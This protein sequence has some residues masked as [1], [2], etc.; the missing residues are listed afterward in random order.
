MRGE[1]HQVGE[2]LQYQLQSEKEQPS[3]KLKEEQK[4][5]KIRGC[6]YCNDEDEWGLRKKKCGLSLLSAV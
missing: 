3:W 4:D 1:T 5:G 6:V 2:I